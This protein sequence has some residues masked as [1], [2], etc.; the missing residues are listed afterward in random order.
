MSHVQQ[1]SRENIMRKAAIAGVVV[2][3]GV[4]LAACSG[5][6]PNQYDVSACKG[7]KETI[8]QIPNGTVGNAGTQDEVALMGWQAIA[9]DA[10][11]KTDI[12]NLEQALLLAN[13]GAGSYSQAGYDAEDLDVKAIASICSGDGVNGIADGW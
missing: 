10:Q 9:H 12:Q 13:P 5:S 3:L 6:Q 8:G 11:L 7:L 4:L 2:V 1:V